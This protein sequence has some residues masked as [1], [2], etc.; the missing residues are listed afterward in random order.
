MCSHLGDRQ[1]SAEVV[2]CPGEAEECVCLSSEITAANKNIIGFVSDFK[3]QTQD[4]TKSP[5]QS[6]GHSVLG[7]RH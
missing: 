1:G 3:G 4:Q 7:L 5:S 6:T 2:L